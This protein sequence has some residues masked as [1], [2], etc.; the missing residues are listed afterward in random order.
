MTEPTLDDLIA[1]LQASRAAA[2]R[3]LPVRLKIEVDD[4]LDDHAPAKQ[5]VSE[6]PLKVMPCIGEAG[7]FLQIASTGAELR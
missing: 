5:F 2:G 4:P 7:E 6:M 3:N 1:R